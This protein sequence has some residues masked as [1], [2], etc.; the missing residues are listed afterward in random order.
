MNICCIYLGLKDL[1]T[2]APLHLLYDHA[3][4]LRDHSG[5]VRF[6]SML[7]REIVARNVW[8]KLCLQVQVVNA[9]E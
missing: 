6:Q 9:G 2:G 3:L 4:I 7:M 5:D 1:T 8:K